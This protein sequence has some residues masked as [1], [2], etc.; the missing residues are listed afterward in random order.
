MS[1]P[2]ICV[3]WL[4]IYCSLELRSRMVAILVVYNSIKLCYKS[5]NDKHF[6]SQISDYYSVIII[7]VHEKVIHPNT[8]H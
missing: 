7:I 4:P 3:N 1:N 5:I 6:I 8:I 2:F